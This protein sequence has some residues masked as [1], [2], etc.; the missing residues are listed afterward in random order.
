MHSGSVTYQPRMNAMSTASATC[1]LARPFSRST[2]KIARVA[3]CLANNYDRLVIRRLVPFLLIF[4]ALPAAASVDYILGVG[5]VSVDGVFGPADP[6]ARG[7]LNASVVP[8]CCRTN[9]PTAATVTI[10]L[11]PGS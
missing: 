7:R 9:D 1:R 3:R 6:G 2:S 4:F 11:P 10:P 8:V 5:G